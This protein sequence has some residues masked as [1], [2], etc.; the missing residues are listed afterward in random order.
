M[1]EK[2][3][4]RAVKRLTPDYESTEYWNGIIKMSLSKFFVLCVLQRD[5]LHGYEIAKQVETCTK[6]SCSPTQ[7]AIYPVL[8]EF[9]QGGYLTSRTELVNG[10]Q[11]KLYAVTDKGRRAFRQAAS[12]W[13][14]V[15]ER[16]KEVINESP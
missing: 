2:K 6:G 10:R 12:A 11:R 13:Q 15:G 16:V 8:K 9:E 4:N 1:L 5:E 14:E 3:S 7:G